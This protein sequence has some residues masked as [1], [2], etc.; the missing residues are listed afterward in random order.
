MSKHPLAFLLISSLCV[1]AAC[2]RGKTPEQGPEGESSQAGAQG[3]DAALEHVHAGTR[4]LT[5]PEATVDYVAAEM[6]GVIMARTKSQALMH[7]DGYRVTLTTP[8]NRVTQIKFDLV[9]AKPTIKQLTEMFGPA[10]EVR[11]GVLYRHDS[12]VT[13]AA[14]VILAIPV[15]MP[16]DEGSLVRQLIIEGARTR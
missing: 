1:A 11:K 2:S 3:S 9:E 4:A 16:A 6:E 5:R 14:I 10:E 15:S 8:G 13:G 7:Y 12:V